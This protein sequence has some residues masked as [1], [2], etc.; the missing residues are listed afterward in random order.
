MTDD[1]YVV[2]ILTSKPDKADALRD[3]LIPATE[4]FRQEDGCRA[5]SLHEDIKRPGRFMTY[6][7]WRD[8]AALAAHMESPTMKAATPE[9][10]AILEG[11]M[12]QHLLGT[13]LQL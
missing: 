1:L 9:L 4:A 10:G 3:L 13:L 11:E 8:E 12:E 5:Y 7:V 2:A 6:E